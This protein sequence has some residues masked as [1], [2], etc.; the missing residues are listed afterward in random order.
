MKPLA[1]NG[2]LDKIVGDPTITIKELRGWEE[3]EVVDIDGAGHMTWLEQPEVVKRVVFPW[4][5]KVLAI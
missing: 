1:L 2:K 3:V 4:L 5:D